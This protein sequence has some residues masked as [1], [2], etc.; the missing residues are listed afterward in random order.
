MEE[1]QVGGNSKSNQ[2]RFFS[3]HLSQEEMLDKIKRGQIFQGKIN[4]NR[5]NNEEGKQYMHI[6]IC[7]CVCESKRMNCKS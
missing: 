3:S 2:D 4:I 1:E 5:A 7:W 6:Y